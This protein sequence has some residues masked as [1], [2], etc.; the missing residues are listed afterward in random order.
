MRELESIAAIRPK[1]LQTSY[2]STQ[3]GI[4]GLKMTSASSPASM[5]FGSSTLTLLVLSALPQNLHQ[6]AWS[7]C[8]S[9]VDGWSESSL[10]VSGCALQLSR[11]VLHEDGSSE[12]LSSF[13][14]IIVT[15]CAFDG[16]NVS[17]LGHVFLWKSLNVD[18][19]VVSWSGF[20]DSLVV[21]FDGEAFSRNTGW[22]EDD[23]WARL[24]C[25][26]FDT[27]GDD[28]TDTLDLVD[29][30]DRHSE[31]LLVWSLGDVYD[32]VQSVQEG[33]SGN[34]L[35]L[36]LDGETLVPRHVRGFFNEVVS[37]ETR[38]WHERDLFGLETNLGKHLLDLLVDFL[39]SFFAVWLWL[40]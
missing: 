20:V 18:T 32:V 33:L 24:E 26:L 9:D 17:N 23:I 36:W 7:L 28:V 31:W 6:L 3:R 29:T 1:G 39:V 37:L 4:F 10:S 16:H 2:A 21:H 8:G 14:W 27:S 22:R 40:G 5:N 38:H 34:F 12:G 11:V 13:W 30:R 19:N 15:I 25:S 35:L